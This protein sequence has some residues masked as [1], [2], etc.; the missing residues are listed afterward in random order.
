MGMEF[1]A[2]NDEDKNTWVDATSGAMNEQMERKSTFKQRS[3]SINSDSTPSLPVQSPT[4]TLE[5]QNII[6]LTDD[7]VA[8]TD[9]GIRAPRWIKTTKCPCAWAVLSSLMRSGVDVITAGHV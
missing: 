7:L 8:E 1:Q 3:G 4:S 6:S 5:R 9:L 2:S